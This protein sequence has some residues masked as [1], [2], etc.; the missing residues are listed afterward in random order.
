MAN[1]DKQ[2]QTW[3]TLLSIWMFCIM[4]WEFLFMPINN[5]SI[6]LWNILMPKLLKSICGKFLCLSSSK[7]STSSLTSFLRY[8]KDTANCYFANFENAWLPSSKIKE[9]VCRKL[10][11]LYACNKSTSSLTCFITHW[12]SKLNILGNSSM[13]RSTLNDSI[14]LKKSLM[15]IC[16]QKTNFILSIFLEILQRYCK[17]VILGTL[18][19][20]AY[21]HLKWYQHLVENFRIYLQAKEQLHPPCFSIYIARICK[22]PILSTLGMP[23]CAHPKW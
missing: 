11:C 2:Q 15:F 13:P 3:L 21:T 14:N 8:C 12:N 9:S 5:D 10:L 22:L 6:T 7:K 16:K 23:G 4:F 19:K 20:P 1:K 17:F 18:H